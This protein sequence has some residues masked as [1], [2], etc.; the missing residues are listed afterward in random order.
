MEHLG[1]V[2]AMRRHIA[3]LVGLGLVMAIAL[4]LSACDIG[5]VVLQGTLT[6]P[7]TGEALADVPVRVYSSTEETV[8]ARGRTGEDGTYRFQAGSLPAGTYR[9]VFSAD[10]WWESGTSWDT[11]TDVGGGRR[12]R[13]LAGTDDGD[14]VG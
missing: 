11:A 5:P 10:H 9:V 12:T 4:G 7:D 2:V 8:L 13:R 14:P 1:R 3:R 6:H